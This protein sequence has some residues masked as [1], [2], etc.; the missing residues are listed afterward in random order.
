ML[1]DI[2]VYDTV[3]VMQKNKAVEKIVFAIIESMDYSKTGV[4]YKYHLVE[5]IV[6]AGWGNNEGIPYSRELIFENKEDLISS[7]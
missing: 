4:D 6:G 1:T 5:S 3:W 2:K 7:L